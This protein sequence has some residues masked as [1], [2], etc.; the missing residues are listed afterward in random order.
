MMSCPYCQQMMLYQLRM[1][2]AP[3]DAL[4]ALFRAMRAQHRQ[5]IPPRSTAS[6]IPYNR[7]LTLAPEFPG[8]SGKFP[9]RKKPT[10]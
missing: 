9:E 5:Y 3:P 1:Q 2:S 10:R 8:M 4:S 7:H 6:E